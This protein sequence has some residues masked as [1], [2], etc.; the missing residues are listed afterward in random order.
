MATFAAA[1]A[2]ES[3][4]SAKKVEL[5]SKITSSYIN[6]NCYS[7]SWLIETFRASSLSRFTRRLFLDSFSEPSRAYPHGFTLYVINIRPLKAKTLK[8]TQIA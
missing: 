3:D 8:S 7:S 5:Y 6:F 1:F 2:E 4:A